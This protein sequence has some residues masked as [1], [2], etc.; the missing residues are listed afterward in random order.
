M[1]AAIRGTEEVALPVTFGILTTVVAFLP[2]AFV[3][4]VRGQMFANIPAVVIPVLIFSLI[5]SK[6]VLP[7]HLKHIRLPNQI[8][9]SSRLEQWQQ[10][11]AN[12][13]EQFV[14]KY[15][16]PLLKWSLLNR[17]LCLSFFVG[18]MVVICLLYTS[19]SPRDV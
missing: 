8:D 7:S 4:G 15:Y 6:F 19:P 14:L 2:L 17:Y 3:E 1:D 16:Q 11:F 9:K 5:E 13:F 18:A 12:G 10:G